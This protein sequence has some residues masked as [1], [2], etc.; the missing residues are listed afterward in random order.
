[1]AL[2]L[3]A[4]LGLPSNQTGLQPSPSALITPTTSGIMSNNSLSQIASAASVEA[5]GARFAQLA[6]QDQERS[7]L[8]AVRGP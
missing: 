2:Y 7:E 5:L 6:K 1:M 3:A 4:S 8:T